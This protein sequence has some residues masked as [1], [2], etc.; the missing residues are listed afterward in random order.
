MLITN[1]HVSTDSSEMNANGK[2]TEKAELQ[3]RSLGNCRRKN[4]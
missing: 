2:R 1:Q 4:T 3:L